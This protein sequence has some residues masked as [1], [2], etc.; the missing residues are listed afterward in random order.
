MHTLPKSQEKRYLSNFVTFDAKRSW[1][2]LF[3]V[4]FTI[5][6]CKWVTPPGSFL[7]VGAFV[8][9]TEHNYDFFQISQLCSVFLYYINFCSDCYNLFF[10]LHSYAF[11]FSCHS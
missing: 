2:Q 5:D 11:L 9:K 10:Q 3:F 6:F 1:E 4:N 7:T 8:Y